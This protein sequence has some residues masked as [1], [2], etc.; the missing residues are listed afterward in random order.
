MNEATV[1]EKDGII[2][3]ISGGVGTSQNELSKS[4]V[5]RLIVGISENYCWA[6]STWK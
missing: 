6:S 2:I 4:E 5:G 1:Q 3:S